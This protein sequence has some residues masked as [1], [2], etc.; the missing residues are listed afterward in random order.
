MQ[1]LGR[2]LLG[3]FATQAASELSRPV[4][5]KRF[6]VQNEYLKS[7][8]QFYEQFESRPR[9]HSIWYVFSALN[10]KFTRYIGRLLTPRDNV[11]TSRVGPAAW[12][13]T[14]H[15]SHAAGPEASGTPIF[16]ICLEYAWYIPC[17]C[18]CFTYTW[19]IH[20]ISKDIPCI[21]IRRLARLRP[22][23]TAANP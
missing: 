1:Q 4:R 15:A 17:I 19:Y 10:Q 22:R 12:N 7:L 2:A 8:I 21:S 9:A 13:S 20:G 6:V 3:P 16:G 5:R 11:C 23:P 14:Q 18:R